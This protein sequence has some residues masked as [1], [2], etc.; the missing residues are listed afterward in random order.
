LP[1]IYYLHF[2]LVNIS[3]LFCTI[4]LFYDA[5]DTPSTSKCGSIEE[6]L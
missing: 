6:E 5:A 4:L 3:F 1:I 2:V